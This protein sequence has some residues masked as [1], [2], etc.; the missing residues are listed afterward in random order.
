M[1]LKQ[2]RLIAFA[3]LLLFA[4]AAFAQAPR[5]AEDFYNRG[6]QRQAAGDLDGALADYAEAI[7]RDPRM[8]DA[9]NNRANVLLQKGDAAAR[10]PLFVE[11]W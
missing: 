5:S 1:I 4:Q 3:A 10:P 11:L 7:K 2:P 6:L 8:H 9:Y